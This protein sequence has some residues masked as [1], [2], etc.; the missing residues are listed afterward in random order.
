M[1]ERF[2][3]RGRRKANPT[4]SAPDDTTHNRHLEATEENKH[5]PV[6]DTKQSGNVSG[7]L[8]SPSIAS[9][10]PPATPH[11]PDIILT[12]QTEERTFKTNGEYYDQILLGNVDKLFNLARSSPASG[13]IVK[14]RPSNLKYTGTLRGMPPPKRTPISTSTPGV[15]PRSPLL[16]KA[17]SSS[18][19]DMFMAPLPVL[20]P[21]APKKRDLNK[22]KSLNLKS[23]AF[24]TLAKGI[25]PPSS[26][27]TVQYAPKPSP[28]TS[29]VSKTSTNTKKFGRSPLMS[30]PEL[31]GSKWKGVIPQFAVPQTS[32]PWRNRSKSSGRRWKRQTSAASREG[33]PVTSAS[34]SMPENQHTAA[35]HISP[36]ILS[37]TFAE[38]PIP[39][40]FLTSGRG[41]T[42]IASARSNYYQ[43]LPSAASAASHRSTA[44]TSS[45]LPPMRSTELVVRKNSRFDV[46][47]SSGK[48][49]LFG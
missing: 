6:D 20:P 3:R 1:F 21:N 35:M 46:A 24:S 38:D 29:I 43:S 14:P 23:S 13:S 28:S 31:G 26:S 45:K 19:A 48:S 25:H 27:S 36:P 7:G 49:V 5:Q 2:F 32:V 41:G 17:S 22:P 37:N 11:T 15:D 40:A 8:L 34:G 47:V 42:N 30:A 33:T 18:P 39:S 9:L 10:T 12:I 4:E 16:A 44:S